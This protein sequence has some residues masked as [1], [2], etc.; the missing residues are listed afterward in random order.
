MHVIISEISST[1]EVSVTTV[2][3]G[4]AM[5]LDSNFPTDFQYSLNRA[6]FKSCT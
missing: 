3:D 2:E 5:K 4:A 1:A 6:E